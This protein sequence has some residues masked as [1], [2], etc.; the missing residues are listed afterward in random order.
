MPLITKLNTSS[1]SKLLLVGFSLC[2]AAVLG[3]FLVQSIQ[4][5]GSNTTVNTLICQ[6]GLRSPA[7]VSTNP[8]NNASVYTNSI[9]FNIVTSWVNHLKIQLNGTQIFDQNVAY[10][11]NLTTT[12]PITGLLPHPGVNTITITAKGGCPESTISQNV[13]IRF[14]SNVLGF[15]RLT[16][17][18]TSPELNGTVSDPTVEIRVTV[19]GRTYQAINHGNGK[20]SL[21]SGTISP[22]LADGNYSVQV[23]TRHPVT[24]AVIR[25]ITVPNALTIDTVAP[26]VSLDDR[27]PYTSRSP[28]FSGTISEP[29]AQVRVNI[30]GRDYPANNHGNGTWSLPSGVVNQLASGTYT[31]TI[32]ATDAA[33]NVTVHTRTITIKAPNELG[34]MALPNT[35]YLRIGSINIPSWLLYILFLLAITL[36]LKKIFLKKPTARP[37]RRTS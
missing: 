3:L 25:N 9:S 11:A 15:Q 26:T 33:G 20:W 13:V 36:L 34:F 5:V 37:A 17:N 19:N 12:V 29:G 23:E 1:K 31:I 8:I 14:D 32:T 10:Q 16:T 7:I 21:P 22:V 28:G 18:N 24:H 4:A 30:N 27:S 6:G 2:L 35:G